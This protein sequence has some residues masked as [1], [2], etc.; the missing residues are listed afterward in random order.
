M[1]FMILLG[2][3]LA[4]ISSGAIAVPDQSTDFAPL[5]RLA[6][7]DSA[8]KCPAPSPQLA[9]ERSRG[10]QARRLDQLPSGRLELAVMRE[11]DGCVIPAVVREGIGGS[12]APEE[13][14][15]R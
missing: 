9:V 2:L 14:G 15:R 1:L 6:D 4:P 13:G 12:A 11:V 10:L 7:D 5:E 8:R 3:A